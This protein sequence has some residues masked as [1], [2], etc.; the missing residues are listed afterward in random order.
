MPNFQNP[1]SA[2]MPVD[3]R[4]ELVALLARHP[5]PRIEDY[6]CAE[7]HVGP[8]R[9]PPAKAFD[10]HGLVLRCGSFSKCLA[11]GY[12]VGWVTA[13]RF[14]EAVGRHKSLFSISANLAA[15]AAIAEFVRSGC[16]ELQQRGCD[17]APGYLFA[18]AMPPDQAASFARRTAAQA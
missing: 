1:T 3:R 6:A 7:L 14:S 10:R 16:Y 5:I 2:L 18:R 12:R 9:P 15:R 17:Q 8:D 4:Q 11:P 13:G